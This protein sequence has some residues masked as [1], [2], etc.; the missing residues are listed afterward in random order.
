MWPNLASVVIFIVVIVVVM[1]ST[2]VETTSTTTECG[3]IDDEGDDEWS[4]RDH[5]VVLRVASQ[6]YDRISHSLS[7]LSASRE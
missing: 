6:V 1:R 5:A 4:S 2:A 3:V 7:L